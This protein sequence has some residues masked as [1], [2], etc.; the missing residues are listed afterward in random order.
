MRT[1]GTLWIMTLMLMV[2]CNHH[3]TVSSLFHWRSI[4]PETD[5]L[6]VTLERGFI[7]LQPS[8]TLMAIAS[9]LEDAAPHTQYERQI[10]SRY[11]YWAGRIA[12]S[13]NG[14]YR[15][16]LKMAR[17]LCDSS[18]FPYDHMR[19]SYLQTIADTTLTIPQRYRRFKELDSYAVSTCDSF[20]HASLLNNMGIEMK[21]AG[22]TESALDNYI[23]AARIWG[24]LG[25]EA[26]RLKTSLNT[27]GIL[28][29][30]G[31]NDEMT[32][33][34][35]QSLLASSVARRDTFF[36]DNLRLNAYNI[37]GDLSLLEDGYASI[38]NSAY[39]HNILKHA[40]EILLCS[41]YLENGDINM[42]HKFISRLLEA[43]K[44]ISD[45][46]YLEKIYEQAHRY[47]SLTENQDSAYL[48]CA[49]TAEMRK[50]MLMESPTL[51]VSS[52]EAQSG[53]TKIRQEEADRRRSD[54]LR[55][56]TII[57]GLILA[58]LIAVILLSHRSHR[59]RLA[60]LQS[61]LELERSQRNATSSALEL[62]EKDKILEE[63]LKQISSNGNTHSGDIEQQIKMHLN[64][65]RDWED[66]HK[67]FSNVHPRFA[68][69]LK[70][71]YP[72]LSEGDIKLATYIKI[73]L[74]AKQIARMLMLQP[75]SVKKNRQRLR[76]RMGLPAETSLEELL[77][78][79]G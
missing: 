32:L 65:R 30:T 26:Y 48:Y 15:E 41:F 4:T 1:C 25:I 33:L 56:A 67:I 9:R 14:N 76:R 73:G 8:D 66:F 61:Q 18:R 34:L 78:H 60:A 46:F 22:L 55:H 63:V 35:C 79:I 50:K 11:Y 40:Y 69:A 2:S 51:E 29:E 19:I 10:L 77:R 20:M 12:M 24:Q 68:L 53:I 70:E 75:D 21:S 64:G 47:F 52:I 36:Y 44:R 42:A 28:A 43:E 72:T 59:N 13:K 7:D 45:T 38:T 39:S 49:L 74:S 37:L 58:G 5:S 3:D 27:L 57:T 23:L 62:M 31:R 17:Q 16:M 6:L 71:R 54:R